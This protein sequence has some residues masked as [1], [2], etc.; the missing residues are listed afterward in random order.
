MVACSALLRFQ[1]LIT[2]PKLKFC[3]VKSL[4]LKSYFLFFFS[5]SL[6]HRLNVNNYKSGIYRENKTKIY[7]VVY[8]L[9]VEW[10]SSSSSSA[11]LQ[12]ILKWEFVRRGEHGPVYKGVLLHGQVIAVKQKKMFKSTRDIWILL[13]GCS[14]ELC[15]TQKSGNAGWLL[16]QKS[17]ASCLQVCL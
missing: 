14:F 9:L 6:T 4:K 1:K 3:L 16:L 7:S 11:S 8:N 17:M 10:F 13:W 2:M 15:T 12:W 5:L